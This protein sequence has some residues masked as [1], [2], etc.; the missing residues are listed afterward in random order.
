ML[1]DAAAQYEGARDM[2]IAANAE[3]PNI[4]ALQVEIMAIALA[5]DA[6]RVATMQFDHGAAG[7][8]FTWDGMQHEYNHHK[9][10]HGKVR[11]DCFGDS[12]EGGCA[13]VVGY[14]D[15][16][17]DIDVWH[18]NKFALLLDRLS[19]YTEEDG[20]SVLENS[21]ILY[22]NELSDGKGH[23]FIDLPYILAGSAGGYFK[24]GEYILLGEGT[25]YDDR[26]APH[27]RLLNT[28]MNAMGIASD[29]F[30][31]EEGAGGE[32]MQGGVYEQLLA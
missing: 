23:S 22:T 12:T 20:K 17:Y 21:V 4:A 8:T 15:M 6:T 1:R 26:V 11:D 32:T 13:D 25:P 19:T 18:Q 30:G 7:P 27:N 14:E 5:C 2:E 3:Y 16:L 31:V 9:L 29:W 28:F 10:S 24:Q